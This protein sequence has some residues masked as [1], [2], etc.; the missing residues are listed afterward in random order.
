MYVIEEKKS[1]SSL[2]ASPFPKTNIMYFY[3]YTNHIK[4]K[5]QGNSILWSIGNDS[6]QQLS[7]NSTFIFDATSMTIEGLENCDPSGMC[8]LSDLNGKHTLVPLSKLKDMGTS[9]T[10]V[11][12]DFRF[13]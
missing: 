2:H 6:P 3:I 4:G 10:N 5:V 11:Y 12:S 1:F 9:E 8:F 13:K 7:K